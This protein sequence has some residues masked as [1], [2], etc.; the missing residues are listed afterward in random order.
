MEF[1]LDILRV[2]AANQKDIKLNTRREIPRAPMY[3]PLDK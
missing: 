3:Y 2:S 1:Q